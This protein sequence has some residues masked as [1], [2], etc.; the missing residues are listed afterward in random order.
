MT[1]APLAPTLSPAPGKI[2]KSSKRQVKTAPE[3]IAKA[4]HSIPEFKKPQTGNG[5]PNGLSP[6]IRNSPD[7]LNQSTDALGAFVP[8]RATLPETTKPQGGS[9][10]S[11]KSQKP[12]PP[13]PQSSCCKKS[14]SPVMNGLPAGK[15]S[16]HQSVPYTSSLNGNSYTP[17]TAP[18]LSPWQDFQVPGQN[19]YMPPFS[20]D[21]PQSGTSA[22]TQNYLPQMPQNGS[23][24]FTNGGISGSIDFNPSV[25]PS[26]LAHEPQSLHHQEPGSFDNKPD[27]DCSCGE[28]CQCLGCASHPF[29]NT[30][31]Q[32]VQEMGL[33]VTLDGEQTLEGFNGFQ[34]PPVHAN[35]PSV[36]P[37]NY[38]LPEFNHTLINGTSHMGMQ[39]YGEVDTSSNQLSNGYSSPPAEY[40]PGQT[41][42]EPSEYYTLEYPVGLP[43]GCSDVTGSCQCGNDCCCVGCLTH[44]GHDGFSLEAT[45]AENIE[46]PTVTAGELGVST[47]KSE[48]MNNFS[49]P[50]S[51]SML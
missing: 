50:S 51:T 14:D 11:G 17:V 5:T 4:L 48:A 25:L 41:L 45:A 36:P 20:F 15:P 37:M 38:S 40:T 35:Y 30:T 46:A 3:T 47:S 1:P 24:A 21:Q 9:C 13:Q 31:R 42:M 7:S 27:H 44:S 16:E 12:A 29:N 26:S 18:P 28:G 23:F 43:S 10:C 22:Y 8:Q 39:P 6:F 32:H 49:S 2:Q 19:H 33:L 34:S